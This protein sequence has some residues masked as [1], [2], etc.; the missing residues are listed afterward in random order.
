MT[1]WAYG[2]LDSNGNDTRRKNIAHCISKSPTKGRDLAILLTSHA[3]TPT[4][5]LHLFAADTETQ[6]IILEAN[7]A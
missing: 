2:E 4:N 3:L 1:F 7:I 6:A 5:V